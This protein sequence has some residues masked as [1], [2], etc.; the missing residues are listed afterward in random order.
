MNAFLVLLI[1]AFVAA[2]S[3]SK[4][5][6]ASLI[7]IGISTAASIA[8]VIVANIAYDLVS[9]HLDTIKVEGLNNVISI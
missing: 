2:I 6:F 7:I 3:G 4:L 5:A 8:F 1:V 9:L